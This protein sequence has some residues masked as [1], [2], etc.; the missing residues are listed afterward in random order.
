MG[1]GGGGGLVPIMVCGGTF[2]RS[3]INVFLKKVPHCW[4]CVYLELF[5]YQGGG[6]YCR[7]REYTEWYVKV[8]YRKG[9]LYRLKQW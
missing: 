1:E 3:I 9:Y 8:R 2:F 6:T 4:F 7:W 5:S